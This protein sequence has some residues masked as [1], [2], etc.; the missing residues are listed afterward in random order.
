MDP[1]LRYVKWKSLKKHLTSSLH[2][3]FLDTENNLADVTLVSDDQ[4]QFHAHKFVLGA[5]S[6]V[7]KN[8]LL[9]NPHAHPILF[10]RGVK[11]QELESILQFMYL[12]EVRVHMVDIKRFLEIARDF[13]IKELSRF[14]DETP[15]NENFTDNAVDEKSTLKPK[16][17]EVNNK[18]EL[19]I[20]CE[21][22][23][24]NIKCENENE[25]KDNSL[26]NPDREGHGL[27]GQSYKCGDCESVFGKISSLGRHRRSKHEG[28][29]FFCNQC[30][31]QA[32]QLSTVKT[33]QLNKH[34]G[35]RYSCNQCEHQATKLAHL[36]RHKENKHEGVRY[37]CDQCEY[38]A[39]HPSHLR[40]HK[41][42]KHKSITRNM[43]ALIVALLPCLG[44]ALSENIS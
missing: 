42:N 26:L 7:L 10:L 2:D 17:C 28:I 15:S 21:N 11:Q 31:H 23:N 32:T 24:E 37:F 34:E 19:D 36:K 13:E 8:L 14:A 44:L 27:S 41:E 30:E 25:T 9:T 43:Q 1:I 4:T 35:V 5:C 12:G 3:L 39:A 38:K 20:K 16:Y 6:S 33:H 40:R 22:E 18:I 29:R